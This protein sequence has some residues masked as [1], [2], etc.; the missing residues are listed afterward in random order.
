[1]NHDGCCAEA[2]ER[3][4][5]KEPQLARCI[6]SRPG[7]LALGRPARQSS[8]Y[9]G[10]DAHV[11]VDGN[12][13]GGDPRCCTSTQQDPQAWWEVDLGDFATLHMV[14][15][16]NRTDEPPDQ[17]MARDKYSNRLVP[18][19]IM[20]SHRAGQE[21]EIPNFKG[22]FLGR[23]PLVSADFWTSDHLSERSRSV[24][25]FVG[26]RARGTLTLKRR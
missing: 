14:K 21:S 4:F 3:R 5:V 6:Y 7:N 13:D 11:G 9:G 16:W 17:T 12:T 15:I 8:C 22:S 18:S 19:W 25:A 2:P 23:F 10:L 24:D 20:A 1:M 26:T